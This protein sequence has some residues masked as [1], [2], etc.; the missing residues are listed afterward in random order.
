MADG[1]KHTLRVSQSQAARQKMFELL[2]IAISVVINLLSERLF[3]T[4]DSVRFIRVSSL[5]TDR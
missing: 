3:Y 5:F 1:S 2:E 4:R